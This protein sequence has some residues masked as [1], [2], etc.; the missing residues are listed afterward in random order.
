MN[1]RNDT[2]L[3]QAHYDDIERR[4][5]IAAEREAEERNAPTDEQIAAYMERRTKSVEQEAREKRIEEISSGW[6]SATP[7]Y[8][9]NAHSGQMMEEWLSARGLPITHENLTAAFNYLSER[10]LI[11][12]N[13]STVQKQVLTKVQQDEIRRRAEAAR[14]PT[15]QELYEMP[16]ED[17]Q[18]LAYRSR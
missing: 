15:V 10:K 9:R 18:S 5:Q 11:E 6:V 2:P 12:T 4:R 17:L 3:A 13:E 14:V 7:E 8:K 16:L 1:F